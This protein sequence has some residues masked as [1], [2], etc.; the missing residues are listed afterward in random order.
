MISNDFRDFASEMSRG[1]AI[2]FRVD[3]GVHFAID[4]AIDLPPI[5]PGKLTKAPTPAKPSPK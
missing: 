1:I 2:D 3:F 4:F 5:L